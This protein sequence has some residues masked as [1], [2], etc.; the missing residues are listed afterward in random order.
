MDSNCPLDF[1]CDGIGGVPILYLV[2]KRYCLELEIKINT[3]MT[4]L[5]RD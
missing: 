5:Y 4:N 3:Y 2:A 1:N